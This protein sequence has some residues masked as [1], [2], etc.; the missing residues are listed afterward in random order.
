MTPQPETTLPVPFFLPIAEASTAANRTGSWSTHQPHY[1]N[2]TAPCTSRCPCGEEIPRIEML[3][4]RG[5]YAR[6]WRTILLENPFPG[7]CGRVCFHPCEDSCNRG[8]FDTPIAINALERFLDDQAK[9]TGAAIDLTPGAPTGRR[10]AIAGAGPA[11]LAAAWFLA[12]LGHSCEVFE[13]APEPGGL[14]RYGIPAYRLPA[15][16]LARE[17]G[18]IES[19]GVHIHCS[20]PVDRAFV[21][22]SRSHFDALF[23]G[24][25]N[26]HSLTLDIPG[27]E[28]AHDGLAFLRDCRTQAI[29]AERAAA[30]H[31]ALPAAIIGGGNSAIDIARTLLRLGRPAAIVY[32]RR[33]KDMP[34]FSQE[35][36]RALQE[37][38]QL[39]ELSAPLAL[40]PAAD[41]F[42][43]T[44]QRMRPG[45]PGADGRMRV[46]AVPGETA[47]LAVAAVYT[48]IGATAA[49][50]W[51]ALIQDETA[52]HFSHSRLLPA[53][54]AGLPV[55]L[56]GDLVNR[57]QSVADAIASGKEA[58]I[59]L[60][61]LL[62]KGIETV[63]PGIARCRVGE[64]EALSM[65]I[66][67]GGG[68]AN[69]SRRVVRYPDLVPDYFSPA[70]AEHGRTLAPA[71]AT[72]SFE[73]V[74]AALEEE[75]A[76]QQA[77][78]CF[79]CG[80]CNDCDICRTFC[81]EVAIDCASARR[82]QSE[83]CK[84]CG[85]CLTECPR[86][87]MVM[88]EAQS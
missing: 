2:K 5:E 88:E 23:V 6:A 82:I 63:A 50:P 11:G 74:E 48:A 17:I 28:F 73:E 59:A 75:R 55:I 66:H 39:I 31:T 58:A 85:I 62:R 38:V 84:G 30:A 43:L 3:T 69:H 81:P 54:A 13:A 87:A 56:G 34:A 44:V 37:G 76:L 80:L 53:S 78:R 77:E 22:A 71:A 83:Y 40:R 51:V 18:R 36:V 79:S 4:A 21:E 49:P 20:A 72:A 61:L 26:G 14:L 42:E 16:V 19:L 70:P 86:C 57:E 12:L 10:I 67:Q 1:Q 68:R 9:A 27:G 47:T 29:A 25:G 7:S 35:V 64:G 65:E 60:D 8:E 52:L 33:R 41:H 15:A 32:R 46:V 24:C 45:E